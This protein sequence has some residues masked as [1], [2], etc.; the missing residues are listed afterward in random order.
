MIYAKHFIF[1][2]KKNIFR[3]SHF[4]GHS[5]IFWHTTLRSLKET[6]PS[7]GSFSDSFWGV[8]LGAF[9][10]RGNCWIFRRAWRLSDGGP[11][12]LWGHMWYAVGDVT[13][14]HS[15]DMVSFWKYRSFASKK[16]PIYKWRNIGCSPIYIS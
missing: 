13:Y 2:C 7:L 15:Q 12:A 4:L 6:I 3:R 9:V 5:P 16:S 8:T 10:I 1:N 11:M 14:P